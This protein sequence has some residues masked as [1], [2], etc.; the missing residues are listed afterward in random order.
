MFFRHE[1]RAHRPRYEL[2]TVK[3]TI[4][5][6]GQDWHDVWGQKKKYSADSKKNF[7]VMVVSIVP[8]VY[9][10]N[11]PNTDFSELIKRESHKDVLFI[12]NDNF[13]DRNVKMQ[14][15]NSARIRP[16]TFCSPPRAIG[17]PT[18]WSSTEGGFKTLSDDVKRAIFLSFERL[19]TILQ[20]HDHIKRVFYSCD[21]N[22]HSSFGFAIF[23][24]HP[25]VISYLK[26]RIAKIPV[27]FDSIGVAIR[28]LDIAEDKIE[29]TSVEYK[30][31]IKINTSFFQARSNGMSSSFQRP[32]S[33]FGN[34][35][36]TIKKTQTSSISRVSSF[37]PF[38]GGSKTGQSAK[39]Q[40]AMSRF[41]VGSS[42]R[43][44]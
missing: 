7:F 14:G 2:H 31:A 37:N 40:T 26:A 16:Y 15:G 13:Q 43:P 6:I 30:K 23:K 39:N 41:F 17:I 33:S 28:A 12:F 4:S 32:M 38:S 42:S 5:G 44:L 18:G 1:F 24:P 29:K 21:I 20:T 34:I 19:N 11:D 35:S 22:D 36:K 25:D 27:R 8:V 9:D 3:Q 10:K